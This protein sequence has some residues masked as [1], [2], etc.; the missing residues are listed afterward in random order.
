VKGSVN[1]DFPVRLVAASKP[2]AMVDLL[3]GPGRMADLSTGRPADG[4]RIRMTPTDAEK[5]A[6]S[7]LAAVELSRSASGNEPMGK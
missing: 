6:R 7:I 1:G 3:I 5:V 4:Y 2:G